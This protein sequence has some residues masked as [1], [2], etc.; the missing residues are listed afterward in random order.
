MYP[1]QPWAPL[2]YL[3]VGQIAV[4]YSVT[5]LFALFLL[6]LAISA[7]SDSQKPAISRA[8]VRR[9]STISLI[10]YSILLPIQLFSYGLHWLNSRQQTQQVI[11]KA[12][13]DLSS[14]RERIN[15]S[16][17]NAQLLAVLGR[18]P[19][20]APTTSS[21]TELAN[22]KKEVIADLD[23]SLSQLRAS[24]QQRR[25]QDLIALFISTLK[26]VLGAAIIAFTFSRV[27]RILKP[28]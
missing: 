1:F 4:D 15:A 26:G 10:I 18:T 2:W 16:N 24:L 12:S 6:L 27:N 28:I 14:L 7:K 19:F 13:S 8:L 3:K 23:F 21:L 22:Q 11:R 5:L 17:S 25:K 20:V 9:F